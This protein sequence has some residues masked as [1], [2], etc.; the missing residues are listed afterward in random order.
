MNA[1]N[2]LMVMAVS[3]LAACHGK[4]SPPDAGTTAAAFAK[5]SFEVTVPLGYA[6]V[7]RIGVVGGGA[8]GFVIAQVDQEPDDLAVGFVG[9]G[10]VDEVLP[11]KAGATLGLRLSVTGVD[12]LKRS[13]SIP[14]TL[15]SLTAIDAEL[16]TAKPIAKATVAVTLVEP[17]FDVALTL[18]STDAATLAQR[19]SIKNLGDDLD[20]L[21]VVPQG[22]LASMV[23]LRPELDHTALAKNEVQEF[24]LVPVLYPGMKAIA[25]NLLV[26][27][28]TSSKQ[29]PVTITPPAGK[30]VYLGFGASWLWGGDSGEHCTNESPLTKTVGQKPRKPAKQDPDFWSKDGM[31]N[32][33]TKG[34]NEGL[35]AGKAMKTMARASWLNMPF[36]ALEQVFK[37]IAR[38]IGE[39]PP[40]SNFQVLARPELRAPTLI[41]PDAA[42]GLTQ[43][44]ADALNALIANGVLLADLGNAATATVDKLGGAK[45]AGNAEWVDK[46]ESLL[47]S[48]SQMLVGRARAHAE[49]LLAF[50]AVAPAALA[51][52]PT[53]DAV[54]AAQADLLA[55]GFSADEL[56]AFSSLGLDA[57]AIAEAKAAILAA[58]PAVAGALSWD[59]LASRL[60][61]GDEVSEADLARVFE[62]AATG[63]TSTRVTQASV[64]LR[65]ELPRGRCPIGPHTTVIKLN[66]AEVGRLVD[67]VPEGLYRF[68]AP[69]SA[70]S[71]FGAMPSGNDLGIDT[72][73]LNTGHLIRA[74]DAQLAIE[75]PVHGELVVAA[76]QASADA[77]VAALAT[78]NHARPDLVLT[79]NAVPFLD[80]A[81]IT[82]ATLVSLPI[83]IWNLGVAASSAT[84]LGVY[85]QDPRLGDPGAPLQTEVDVPA[86]LPGQSIK[87][88]LPLPGRLLL[89]T[90]D[91]LHFLLVKQPND[92]QL[93]NNVVQLTNE[94]TCA[95]Q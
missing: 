4:D 41:A 64:L 84:K 12:A 18:V 42:T 70:V 80:R 54:I 76:D 73:G 61:S 24:E 69:A 86:V 77:L 30:G 83:E 40:D 87:V 58:D 37:G 59:D 34:T 35:A 7:A 49:L 72:V 53:V 94:G 20:M 55:N 16:A 23:A 25:G 51:D 36:L 57:A 78:A 15:Y 79:T 52:G 3:G 63:R 26:R 67:T 65:F 56:A 17:K 33:Y 21:D 93:A 39:D 81:T 32:L 85:A 22:M 62:L 44:G 6:Q 48:Y 1:R 74:L 29:V 9:P 31:K 82:D 95:A 91:P 75:A 71:F 60:Y 92:Y 14:I 38:R 45:L 47:R 50:H 46:Q 27:V 28:P 5:S 11:L 90:E 88:T 13:Y 89:S 19:W 10:N 68:P 8:D 43:A 2:W 66:G